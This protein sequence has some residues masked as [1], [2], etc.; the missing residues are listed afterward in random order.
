MSDGL[1]IDKSILTKLEDR[2]I[3]RDHV[4]ECFENRSGK[5]L[6]DKRLKHKTQ[7]PTYW[8]VSETN[9]GRPLKVC[10]MPFPDEN[11]IKSAYEPNEEEIRIYRKYGEHKLAE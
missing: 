6:E 3:S 1:L 4:R 5:F 11:K 9:K 7:P 8:F 2:N 10:F